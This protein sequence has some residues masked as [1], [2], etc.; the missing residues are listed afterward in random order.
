MN[1]IL[2]V[3]YLGEE[4]NGAGGTMGIPG[5]IIQI[6]QT[7]PKTNGMKST[8]CVAVL[9]YLGMKNVKLLLYSVILFHFKTRKVITSAVTESVTADLFIKKCNTEIQFTEKGTHT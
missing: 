8:K 9:S 4:V 2:P 7:T 6:Y 1:V 3:R 5:L